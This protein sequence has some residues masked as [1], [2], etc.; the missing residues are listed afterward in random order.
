MNRKLFVGN[1]PWSIDSQKLLALFLPF[2]EVI[3]CVVLAHRDGRSK[4][5]GFVTFFTDEAAIEAVKALHG[6][7]LQGRRINVGESI[8]QPRKVPLQQA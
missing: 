1:L 8:T 7:R 4:G 6:E 3:E 2:G 5:Y